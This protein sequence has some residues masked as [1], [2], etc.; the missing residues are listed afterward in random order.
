MSGL[1]LYPITLNFRIVS[2]VSTKSLLGLGEL[3]SM[4]GLITRPRPSPSPYECIGLDKSI[5]SLALDQTS[6]LNTNCFY[7]FSRMH[8]A[9][10][11]KT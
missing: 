2:A 11:C 4:T 10:V 9:F 8:L 5:D 7:S 6:N 1:G 3:V